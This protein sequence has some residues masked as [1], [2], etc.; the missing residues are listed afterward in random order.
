MWIIG[1]SRNRS[2]LVVRR[3]VIT[4]DRTPSTLTSVICTTGPYPAAHQPSIMP[5]VSTST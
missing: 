1:K 5:T 3:M 2:A 4:D